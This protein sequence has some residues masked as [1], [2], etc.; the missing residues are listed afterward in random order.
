MVNVGN[1]CCFILVLYL[2]GASSSGWL[3]Q[4][5][6]MMLRSFLTVSPDEHDIIQIV[7]INWLNYFVYQN[8]LQRKVTSILVVFVGFQE[9]YIYFNDERTQ[10]D[11]GDVQF[12]SFA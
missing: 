3:L 1:K 8:W 12:C 10:V 5:D 9:A 6:R 4:V 2:D 7:L 11:T